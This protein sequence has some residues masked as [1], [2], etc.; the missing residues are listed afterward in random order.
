MNPEYWYRVESWETEVRGRPAVTLYVNSLRVTR[1]TPCGVRLADGSWCSNTS[2]KRYA[3]PTIEEAMNSFKC[4][5]I[6][7]IAILSH[8]LDKAKA[9][10]DAIT[11]NTPEEIT[12][13]VY[14]VHEF[15]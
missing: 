3:Y 4:R 1:H 7:Q 5:K 2:V 11:K 12:K 9:E 8:R 6:R 14:Y 15:E 13:G 10:L